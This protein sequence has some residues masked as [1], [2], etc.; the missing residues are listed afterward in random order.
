MH[1]DGTADERGGALDQQHV[2]LP[3]LSAFSV[4]VQP[5]TTSLKGSGLSS[6]PELLEVRV[7]ASGFGLSMAL[8]A[9]EQDFEQGA[10]FGHEIKSV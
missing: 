4:V 8:S 5:C 2:H 10:I 1:P 9:V 3:W 6:N 7:Q